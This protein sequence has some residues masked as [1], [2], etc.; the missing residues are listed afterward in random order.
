VCVRKNQFLKTIN[1]WIG[2]AGA[3]VLTRKNQ[4]LKTINKWVVYNAKIFL[5]NFNL[6]LD[7]YIDI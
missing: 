5:E 7:N 4:F 2:R 6:L 3:G 1:K